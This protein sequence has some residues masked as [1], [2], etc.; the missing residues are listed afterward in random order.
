MGKQ[1]MALPSLLPS[2][3]SYSERQLPIHSGIGSDCVYNEWR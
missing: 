1:V 2:V 3:D